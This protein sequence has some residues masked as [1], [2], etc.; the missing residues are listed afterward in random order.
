M[1]YQL[2]R[3]KI[4]F[5]FERSYW[6]FMTWWQW[7]LLWFVVYF[8]W[9]TPSLIFCDRLSGKVCIISFCT[10]KFTTDPHAAVAFFLHQPSWYDVLPYL[11]LSDCCQEW[12]GSYQPNSWFSL[13]SHFYSSI[14]SQSPPS[15]NI[16]HCLQC[17]T[18][19]AALNIFQ[20]FT[21]LLEFVMPFRCIE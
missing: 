16:F 13:H 18:P 12:C 5:P 9:E 17:C 6:K 3:L 14:D 8:L 20:W 15:V 1:L 21:A 7:W 10:D 2:K 19:P 4:T 11:V